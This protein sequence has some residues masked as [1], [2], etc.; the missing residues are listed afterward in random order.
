M[1]GSHTPPLNNPMKLKISSNLAYEGRTS[2]SERDTY[3][4][5]AAY[6]P[7]QFGASLRQRLESR[8]HDYELPDPI[9]SADSA[10]TVPH[11]ASAKSETSDDGATPEHER[12]VPTEQSRSEP[13]DLEE[14]LYTTIEN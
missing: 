8:V 11:G 7:V 4:P 10:V 1:E 6:E 5:E 14:R 13:Q 12:S 2:D 9:P 3:V